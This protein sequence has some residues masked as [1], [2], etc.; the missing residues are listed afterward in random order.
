ME[1]VRELM[2]I[3]LGQAGVQIGN[4]FWELI[5]LEHGVGP[6]GCLEK[7]PDNDGSIISSV[8]EKGN[9]GVYPRT[10]MADLEPSVIGKSQ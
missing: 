1:S 10:V 3:H 2:S 6:D 5:C 4:A 8:F 9:N 7:A